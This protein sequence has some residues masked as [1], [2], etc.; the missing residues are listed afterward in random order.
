MQSVGN[1]ARSTSTFGYATPEEA[2]R[3]CEVCGPVAPTLLK[4][5]GRYVTGTCL[6]QRQARADYEQ[7]QAAQQR[8]ALVAA[9]YDWLSGYTMD[10]DEVRVLAS[11]SFA[12]FDGTRQPQALES[13]QTFADNLT[14]SL[15]LHGTYGTGKTHLLAALC[16]ELNS[17]DIYCRFTTAPNLFAAIGWYM[18]HNKDYS[19]LIRRAVSVPLLVIDDIDKARWSEFREEVYF[20][21]LDSRVTAKRP[22]A[23]STNKLDELE[24]YVGGACVSRLSIRQIAEE[25]IGNDYRKELW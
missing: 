11:R 15:V 4:S 16:Q 1:I 24:K 22:T 14:G 6:C 25:M 7:R 12:N 2:T 3:T 23:I 21:I 5:V 9:T 20:K 19:D 10:A 13:V 17:R 18:N 8:Q